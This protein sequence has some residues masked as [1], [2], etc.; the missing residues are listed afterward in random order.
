MIL[1]PMV[2]KWAEAYEQEHGCK[3]NRWVLQM[4][5]HIE[6]VRKK[7]NELGKKDAQQGKRARPASFFP[8]IVRKAFG[9]DIFEHPDTVQAVAEV[10]QF[11][12][13]NGYNN[14]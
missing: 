4:A 7:L 10:W 5:E 14:I 6:N 13:M 9:T 8:A 1:S 3:P 11:S 2:T 12:Y